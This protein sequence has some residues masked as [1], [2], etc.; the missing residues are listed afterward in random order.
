[1][2]E[3][4]P[5]LTGSITYCY[6]ISH[7]GIRASLESE[8]AAAWLSNCQATRIAWGAELA[9]APETGRIAI[10]GRFRGGEPECVI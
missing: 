7:P 1:M 3:W 8:H 2:R 6:G 5:D 9:F 10:P 4:T